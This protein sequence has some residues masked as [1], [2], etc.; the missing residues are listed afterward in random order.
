MT[1][2]ESVQNAVDQGKIAAQNMADDP[3]IYTPTPWFWS[4][5]YDVKLQIVGL[6]RGFDR[7][8]VQPAERGN[9]QYVSY[10]A[11]GALIA[12]DAMND[13]RAYLMANVCL[14]RGQGHK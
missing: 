3:A 1:R 12:R 6:N 9:G 14:R 2:L 7:T 8:E 5:L 4:D 13:P 10:F 11:N